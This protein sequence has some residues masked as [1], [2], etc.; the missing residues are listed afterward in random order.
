[1]HKFDRLC[2]LAHGPLKMTA[3]LA[4]LS[5]FTSVSPAPRKFQRPEAKPISSSPIF[6]KYRSWVSMATG[7]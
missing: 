5:L 6:R 3:G 4:L 2:S 1:M 7:F